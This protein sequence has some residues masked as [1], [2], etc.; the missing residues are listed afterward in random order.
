MIDLAVRGVRLTGEPDG[1]LSDLLVDQGRFVAVV[2]AAGPADAASPNAGEL[3]AA[4][5]CQAVRLSSRCSLDMS[6]GG[7]V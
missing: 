1:A 2:P 7:P 6:N 5:C 4:A 3:R